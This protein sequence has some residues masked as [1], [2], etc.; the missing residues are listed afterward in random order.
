MN[1]LIDGK[2]IDLLF[3]FVEHRFDDLRH[4]GL[5]LGDRLA[6]GHP[7]FDLPLIHSGE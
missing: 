5:A 3:E 6:D 2:S 1:E 4:T 7:I